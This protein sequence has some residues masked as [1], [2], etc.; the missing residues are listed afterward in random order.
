MTSLGRWVAVATGD[1]SGDTATR[2]RRGIDARLL[3][4]DEAETLIAAHE[5]I[6]GLLLEREIAA[7]RSGVPADTYLAPDSLDSLTRRHLRESFRAIA[8]V[9]GRLES[10]WTNRAGG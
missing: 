9:Q 3:T 10:I 5:Q 8:H 2:L 1:A 4:H 6:F 7:I